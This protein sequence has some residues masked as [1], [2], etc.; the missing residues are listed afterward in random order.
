[1]NGDLTAHARESLNKRRNIRL[2]WLERVL[3]RPQLIQADA[4]DAE[5]EHRL[6]RIDEFEGRVSR[7]IA[8]RTL[9]R[10]A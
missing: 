8:I 4:L 10:S 9:N 7:V 1:M 2:A 3:E 6:G 5:L